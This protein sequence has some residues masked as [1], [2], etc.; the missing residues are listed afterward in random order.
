V[1]QNEEGETLLGYRT[2]KTHTSSARNSSVHSMR[3]RLRPR[4][5]PP[6]CLWPCLQQNQRPLGVGNACERS[7]Q[8]V[9]GAKKR[10]GSVHDLLPP[11]LAC[12]AASRS[13]SEHTDDRCIIVTLMIC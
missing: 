7:E 4:P 2:R 10:R 6:P 1:T 9:T 12:I 11:R 13:S 8:G 5:G 3:S